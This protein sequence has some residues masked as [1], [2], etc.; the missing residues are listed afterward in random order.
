MIFGVGTDIIEIDR[1]PGGRCAFGARFAERILGPRELERYKW[2]RERS[3]ERGIRISG[4]ALR[5]QG[6]VSKALGLG[7]RSR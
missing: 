5:G 3:E 6:A 2:R 4:N 7:M 1:N